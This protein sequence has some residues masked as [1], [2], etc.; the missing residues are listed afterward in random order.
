MTL[1]PTQ[2]VT[3]TSG[4][5]YTAL[6]AKVRAVHLLA[7]SGSILGWDQETMMPDGGVALRAAQLAQLA[8]LGHQLFTSREM[9]D[10]V[11][12]AKFETQSLPEHHADRVDVREIER[13]WSKATKLPES[14]VS[15]LAEL[16]S[17]AM[18]E[19]A[20][21]RQDNN[22][23]HFLPWLQKTVELSRRKAECLGWPEGG[24]PW[25]ALADSY[26]PGL[27]ASEVQ[28]VFDPLRVRL[29]GLL[30]RLRGGTRKPSNAFNE[31]PLAIAD[32]E[33]FM[34]HIAE[35]IGFDFSRGRLDRSTHPFCGGSHCNDVRMTTR[36]HEI[37]LLD[38]LGSTMHEC[39]HG[40]YEQGL[41]STR[42][43]LP[44]GEAAGL[45]VHESQSRLWENQ[46]GR[47]AEFWKWCQGQ[48]P[49]FFGKAC[50]HFSLTDLVDGANIVE[51]GFIR[52]EADEG[53]YNMHIMIRFQLE[54]ALM[55][56]DLLVADLPL[57]WNSMYAD[58]LG[59]KV[60]DDRR[61]CLQDVHWSMG[62]IGYF[63]TYTLGTLLSAQLFEKVKVDV[64][65]LEQGISKG[66]FKPLLAWLRTHVHAEGRRYRLDGLCK[67][68]TGQPL[69]ADPLMRHLE[70]KLLPLYGLA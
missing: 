20:A 33:R 54:R 44:M 59:L 48:L 51:P 23:A 22:F 40:M 46:V 30:D 2:S 69:S 37:C 61:G 38:A 5:A 60:P 65:G 4:K 17:K 28:R 62:A 31:Q 27:Q 56:G 36:Y 12:A 64:P 41:Q 35:K 16:S 15:E 50:D 7:S 45:S 19:W 39:G 34:K 14:L 18:H 29:Q 1:A 10:L 70:G 55:K 67:K 57:A 24:E 25:D 66:E 68:V 8:R 42:I 32:Q 6:A 26:E 43:G 21:A 52:V 3:E 53:T 58:Y 63:P 11:A 9:G 13:D 47:S 49:A